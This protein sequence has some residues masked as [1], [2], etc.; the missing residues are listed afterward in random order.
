MKK[1]ENN[2][3]SRKKP[4][5]K[6]LLTAVITAVISVFISFAVFYFVFL[7]DGR[8]IKL[9][10][11][12]AL[13]Q[14]H[15][16]GEVDN[17]QLN[18]SIIEGYVSGLNDKFASYYDEQSAEK[19][20]ESLNGNGSG[21]G[22]IVTKHPDTEYLYVKNVYDGGP[23]QKA[24]ILVG[25]QIA[26]VDGVAVETTGYNQAVDSI[27]RDVG[28][29][30]TL[31]LVRGEKRLDVTARCSDFTSQT[32]FY[33]LYDSGYAYIEITSFNNETPVQFE[34]AVNQLV[35][36][37]A[38]A[39]IFDLRGNGGGTVESVTE[40]IDFLCPKGTIMTAKYADGSQKVIAESDEQEINVP[41]VVL[42]DS[43][44]ASASELFTACIKDFGKG[45]SIGETTYG[46]GVM[47]T[48]YELYDGSDVSF[49]VAEFFP[50]SLKSFNEIGISPDIEV[51]L[52]DTQKKY[53]YQLTHQE[54][55]VINAAVK[56]LDENV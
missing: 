41:M 11:L 26:A 54:D 47:Q 56:Y 20:A 48:T 25:D 24:G 21:I 2:L 32:V 6:L 8:Y 39:L 13:I 46:K 53:R 23:A 4:N 29:A 19:R 35:T 15:F 31:T 22:I 43:S 7:G 45:I 3:P 10:Q 12:D 28:E 33:T 16:Y 40:M 55:P 27:I 17:S 50:H 5:I 52:N 51:N 42:T 18:D 34:N 9:K 36:K 14:N 37:G 44:T 30:V 1:T 49:T 38:S